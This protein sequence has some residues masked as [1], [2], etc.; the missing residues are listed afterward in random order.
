MT[1]LPFD[2]LVDTIEELMRNADDNGYPMW[3]WTPISIV[4]DLTTYGDDEIQSIPEDE[5]Y[6]AVWAVLH[7]QGKAP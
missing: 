3:N 4:Y 6:R 2:K 5:L 1:I 7:R